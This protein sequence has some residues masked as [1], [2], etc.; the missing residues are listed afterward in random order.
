LAAIIK[1]TKS[2]VITKALQVVPTKILYAVEE[3]TMD[4]AC[5]MDW[6]AK[7]NFPNAIHT[8]DRF[9]FQKIVS[10][11]L[12]EMRMRIRREIIDD[13]NAKVLEA[14]KKGSSYKPQI[15]PNGDTPKQLIARGRHL[16]FKPRNKWTESQKER[17]KILF[18]KYPELEEAY[19]L[20]MMFRNIFEN[21]KNREDAKTKLL[22]W[23][24]KVS[25]KE[26]PEMIS[27]ANTIKVNEG[28]ILN[29]FHSRSTNASAES[30]NAKLKGFRA[31]LRGVRDINFFL[32]RVEK[33]Y[34]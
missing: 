8:A 31:L 5:S 30:F 15:H 20:S 1:G 13:F 25:S 9:H 21:T 17:A 7:I 29:Y 10:E 19:N 11:G 14:R 28:K 33:L 3:I 27:A 4:L 34:A 18:A 22:K 23:Y 12:Q 16:L 32:F 24:D 6:I 2:A 26:Y